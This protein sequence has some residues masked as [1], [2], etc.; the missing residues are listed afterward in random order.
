MGISEEELEKGLKNIV[1]ILGK[2]FG[3]E[4]DCEDCTKERGIKFSKDGDKVCATFADFVNLQES[5][6]GFGD[7]EE[8]A[9]AD[10]LK[11]AEKAEAEKA[12]A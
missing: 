10:L 2:A 8:E 12:S 5:P 6:A 9:K 4:C 7:T 3:K 1:D 11:N